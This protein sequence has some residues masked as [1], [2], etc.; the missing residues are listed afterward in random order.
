MLVDNATSPATNYFAKALGGD[1]FLKVLSTSEKNALPARN[2]DTLTKSILG[3]ATDL[4]DT[5]PNAATASNYIGSVPTTLLN[6]GE[7]S[8]LMGEVIATPPAQ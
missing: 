6:N 7:P 2:Y 8:V 1:E 5:G 4:I 3:P